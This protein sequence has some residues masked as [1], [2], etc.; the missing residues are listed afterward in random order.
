MSKK[1]LGQ[2]YTTRANYI[3]GDLLN[4]FP[5]N[6]TIIDPFSGNW[7]LLNLLNPSTF[8]LFGYDIEP[9]N[10]K[11]I[12]LDTLLEPLDYKNKW[13][14]TNPPFLAKNKNKDKTIYN[15]YNVDDLYEACLKSIMNCEGGVIILPL[16]FLSKRENKIRREFLSNFKI[17]KLKIFEEQ[18][19]NDTTYTICS[20]SFLRVPNKD[21]EI[22]TTF[23]PSREKF[24]FKLE[25]KNDYLI[26]SEFF[27]ALKNKCSCTKIYRLTKNKIPNSKIFLRALDTGSQNGRIKLEIKDEPFYGKDTDRA[28]ATICFSKQFSDEQ[29]QKIC[30]K[31]NSILEKFRNQYNSLFLMQFRNSTKEYSRKRI[32]FD[33]A[34]NLIGHTIKRLKFCSCSN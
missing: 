26:G 30:D 19:F 32:A 2:F 10:N 17:Q 8:N 1:Q 7:D 16:G 28:F 13:V 25:Q 33:D 9:Q 12:K 27:D 34:Y 24:N 14:L 31:F 20:F 23:Y 3:V 29:Q 18:V 21:Q 15:L 6:S 4:I 22:S 11:T 5:E